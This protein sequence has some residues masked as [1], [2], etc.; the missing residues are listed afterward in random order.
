M[1]TLH[2]SVY[3]SGCLRTKISH[4][5]DRVIMIVHQA[6]ILSRSSHAI[7]VCSVFFDVTKE[8]RDTITSHHSIY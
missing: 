1:I 2:R 7:E 3:V 4:A 5:N 6:I 8:Q